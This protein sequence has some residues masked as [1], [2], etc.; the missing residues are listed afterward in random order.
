MQPESSTTKR[1]DETAVAESAIVGQILGRLTE[2]I[3]KKNFDNWFLGRC[4][5]DVD[6]G[7][8]RFGVGSPFVVNWMQRK[9]RKAL[10]E[11]ASSVLGPSARVRLD[12]D[13]RV[14]LETVKGS[15]ASPAGSSQA[16]DRAAAGSTARAGRRF[17]DLQDFVVGD[18]NRLALTAA[19]QICDAPAS[20]INT[21]Y[22]H[23]GVGVGKTHLLEGIYRRF[24]KLYPSLQVNYLTA[25]TFTNYFTAALR[26]HTTPSFRQRFRSIDV[27]LVDDVDFLDAKKVVQEEFLHTIKQ[28]ESHGRQ[29]VLTGNQHPRLLSK[30]SEELTS[31]FISG[32]VCR[33]EPPE[34]ASRREI[35]RRMAEKMTVVFTPESL[36]TVAR[37]FPHSVRELKGAMH[38]LQNWSI[39]SGHRRI[40]GPITRKVLSEL[41]RDCIRI[42]GLT[43]VEKA[44]CSLFG[45]RADEL[46]SSRRTRSLA[47]PRMLAMFLARK[48]TQA[49][50]SEIGEFFGGR[51]HST[52]MS[53]VSKVR[54]WLET[55]SAMAVSSD[56]WTVREVVESI[57][58]Q[59]LAG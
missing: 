35:V 21:L 55:D 38:C 1:H 48:H 13:S 9:F 47:Q 31:R 43:D 15:P 58:Q 27:L 18:S 22:I 37:R 23:G 30:V 6:G 41:E 56:S 49:A 34:L 28:L 52:V 54:G 11:S 26:E 25:E 5:V 3:G 50:F 51:N 14:M 24:R 4:T 20:T 44:V 57:E 7:D 29:V 17:A 42:V 33:I 2:L 8:V 10:Q 40:T 36:A 39:A 59:L 32:L 45:L 19:S 16:R 53:A 12:V 46:K